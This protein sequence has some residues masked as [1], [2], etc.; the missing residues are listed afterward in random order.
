MTHEKVKAVA[1]MMNITT[2]YLFQ[3]AYREC[4]GYIYGL[5]QPELVHE[6][7]EKGIASTPLYVT[8]WINTRVATIH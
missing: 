4:R 5:K 8:E 7:W 3:V 1:K 6:S 2:E